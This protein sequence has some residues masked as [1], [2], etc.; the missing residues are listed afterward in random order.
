M[1]NK[2]PKDLYNHILWLWCVIQTV[3]Y[4]MDLS[5]SVHTCMQNIVDV[6]HDYVIIIIVEP[7]K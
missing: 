5:V 7:T 4:I 3:L 6:T 2:K 1:Y